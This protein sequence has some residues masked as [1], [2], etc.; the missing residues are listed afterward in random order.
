MRSLAVAALVS[1]ILL[2]GCGGGSGGGSQTPA[3]P[4]PSAVDSPF[5]AHGGEEINDVSTPELFA[6]LEIIGVKYKRLSGPQALIWGLIEADLD[7]IYDWTR[8]DNDL[9]LANEHGLSLVVTI[10][11]NNSNDRENCGSVNPCDQDKYEAF[12]AAAIQRYGSQVKYWQPENEVS[13]IYYDG[14]P[15]EYAYLLARSY[16]VIKDNCA[17]CQVL[18]AGMPDIHSD[19]IQFYGEVLDVL[20]CD[21]FD[22]FDLH[23]P[24]MGGHEVIEKKY[25]DLVS[26]LSSYGVQDKPIWS[27]EFGPLIADPEEIDEE[28]RMMFAVGLSAGFDKLFWRVSECP[29]CILDGP[30]SRTSTWDS[31]RE[32]VW[33]IDGY[34]SVTKESSTQVR[35]DFPD[36][37]STFISIDA[38][39]RSRSTRASTGFVSKSRSEAA[40]P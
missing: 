34:S 35:F 14:S 32:L 30:G 38:P 24:V 2:A 33:Q 19:S 17:D 5:G 31:Y 27:T 4:E 15:A 9:A 29:S 36:G 16:G 23:T 18:I 40:T 10:K 3:P 12:L 8:L 25:K 28:L 6:D 21:C 7:G 22:I 20:D 26:F 1:A 37:S 39:A 13:G 11:S